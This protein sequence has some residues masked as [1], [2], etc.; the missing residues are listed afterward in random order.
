MCL[1]AKGFCRQKCHIFIS[2]KC[3]FRQ[4]ILD[5]CRFFG[6][7]RMTIKYFYCDIFT[8]FPCYI[9]LNLLSAVCVN[10]ISARYKRGMHVL[11]TFKILLLIY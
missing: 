8:E 7:Q 4:K 6:H 5:F 11:S 9:V 2:Q 1:G 3:R 10:N